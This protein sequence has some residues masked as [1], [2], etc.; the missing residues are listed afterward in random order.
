[1]RQSCN[2]STLL[3]TYFYKFY[4]RVGVISWL[5]FHLIWKNYFIYWDFDSKSW[6]MDFFTRFHSWKKTTKQ[7]FLCTIF[8]FLAHCAYWTDNFF[9]FRKLI[10]RLLLPF[11]FTDFEI[12]SMLYV[13]Y[14][15]LYV[16]IYV[17]IYTYFVREYWNFLFKILLCFWKVKTAFNE[18]NLMLYHD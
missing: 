4:G 15:V 10:I 13:L 17:H 1:M 5:L 9:Y 12:Q 8:P 7:L 2:H 18:K 6:I 11:L 16:P 14:N 3:Q